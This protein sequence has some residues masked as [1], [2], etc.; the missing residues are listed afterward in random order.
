MRQPIPE[1]TRSIR[2]RRREANR[3]MRYHGTP[4]PRERHV[5][6]VYLS[7]T[8]VPSTNTSLNTLERGTRTFW[9]R[10]LRQAR[11]YVE[12]DRGAGGSGYLD[13]FEYRRCR[14]CL[15]MLIGRDAVDYRERQRWPAYKVYWPWGPCCSPDCK[16][17]ARREQWAWQHP[18][19]LMR[20]RA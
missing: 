11:E 17:S 7:V 1:L 16:P 19:V 8:A 20:K 13:T 18:T 15:R 4:V 6:R 3:A 14:V 2:K 10:S 5:H 9:T 12:R